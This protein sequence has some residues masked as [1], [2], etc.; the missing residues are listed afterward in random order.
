MRLLYKAEETILHNIVPS[1]RY[2][3]Q[4]TAIK[5]SS[6]KSQKHSGWYA[7]HYYSTARHLHHWTVRRATVRYAAISHCS[8]RTVL[9]TC[10]LH[11][12]TMRD[13]YRFYIVTYVRSCCRIN[14][15]FTEYRETSLVWCS[16]VTHAYG[17]GANTSN[18]H[19]I[20]PCTQWMIYK[21]MYTNVKT[22]K[23]CMYFPLSAALVQCQQSS[24]QYTSNVNTIPK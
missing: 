7:R 5:S 13:T 1:E 3:S 19:V 4:V 2:C 20:C 8:Y 9:F 18:R 14:T 16:I 12:Q 10:F 6:N 21:I 22:R 23:Q 11:I 24:A 17:N 15:L